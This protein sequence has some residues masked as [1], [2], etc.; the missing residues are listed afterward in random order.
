MQRRAL[1]AVVSSPASSHASHGVV[2]SMDYDLSG[3]TLGAWTLERVLGEGAMGTVYLA[4]DTGGGVAAVK[5]LKAEHAENP[6]LVRRFIAEA[7]AVNAIRHEHIVDVRTFGQEPRPGRK[8]LAFC[9]MELLEG[10]LLSDVIGE[11]FTVQRTARLAHQLCQ[12]LHAAH[13]IGVV[14][15]DVK[16]ENLF[17]HRTPGDPEFLKVLDFGIAKLLKPIGDLPQSGTAAGVVIGT[18]EYMAPEQAL[19]APT[20]RRADVYAVGLILYELL[21]GAQPFRATTFGRLM[22][23]ITT[24]PPPPLPEVNALGEPLHPTLR[25]TVL[26]CLAKEPAQRFATAAELAQALEPFVTGA[27]V[28]PPESVEPVPAAVPSVPAPPRSASPSAIED[29]RLVRP[30]R[31]P[32][33]VLGLVVLAMGV[34]A[35]LL[36]RGP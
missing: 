25:A 31:L 18:P 16:P 4:R 24:K 34:A 23:E 10:V 19:G 13:Q 11:H 20:D 2:E 21:S 15:R 3:S 7:T 17:L 8:P 6:D 14:H 33:V 1:E 9:V 28:P 36:S 27:P 22:V 30:S 12:A 35:V 26:R 32:W 29:A 5:V